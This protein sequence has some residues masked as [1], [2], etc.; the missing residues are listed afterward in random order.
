MTRSRGRP[1]RPSAR[2][3]PSATSASVSVLALVALPRPEVGDWTPGHVCDGAQTL[4]G[5]EG[6]G[7]LPLSDFSLSHRNKGRGGG[8]GT[9]PRRGASRPPLYFVLISSPPTALPQV[10][11]GVPGQRA[12]EGTPI[13]LLSEQYLPRFMPGFVV[14]LILQLSLNWQSGGGGGGLGARIRKRV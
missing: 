6:G 13:F 14:G 3:G 10:G 11:G 12:L 8:T 9:S 1:S 4:G 2:P 7:V 5:G